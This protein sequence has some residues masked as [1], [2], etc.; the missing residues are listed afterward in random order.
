M[1]LMRKNML[2]RF[3]LFIDLCGIILSFLISAWIR[4]GEITK[5]WFHIKI[6]G[7]AFSIVIFIYIAIYFFHDTYS[8]L[9]KR[10]FF[11]EMIAV[12]RIN[13]I[14][15]ITLTVVMYLFQGGTYYSRI[16]FFCFFI[17]NT[18]IC[19]LLRQYFKVLLLGVY[20]KSSLSNKIMLIT[21]SNH[22]SNIIARIRNENE[23][24]YQITSLAIIDVDMVGKKI[25]GI[26]VKANIENMFNIA[27]REVIDGVFIHLPSDW[28][29]DIH[30]E[31]IVLELQNMGITVD[32]SINTFGLKIRE[33]VIRET[34]GYHVLTFSSKLF[35]ES[36]M[37]I[38]RMVDIL[39]GI[40]GCVITV[41]I[42][43]IIAPMI[44]LES[45]GPIFFTQIRIGKNGRR[46]K[47]YKFRSMYID[48]EQQKQEL[49]GLNEMNGLMFKI[50]NDPRVTQVGKF[51]R[52][53]SLDEFPQF[54]NVLKGEMSLVGTRPPTE[55]EFIQYEARHKRRLALKS[56]VT[57][58]W[59]VSGRS[60]ITDFEDVVKMDLEYI[61]NWSII[62]DFKIL[63][64]TVGVV[65]FG[66]GAK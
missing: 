33:K 34:S 50:K 49:M 16:F 54:F 63:I 47:L 9:F 26:E 30:L 23:W 46:F 56:G 64:K 62:M 58:L 18:L 31:E 19:Y 61:D 52:K 39:G 6:Y 5:E 43:V 1:D 41:I 15:A 13:G 22:I 36:Q 37:V 40:V 32:I 14:L 42:T 17:L 44:I 21:T 65:L 66:K 55:S 59:Q 24:E 29:N 7:T 2:S 25:D 8:R 27:K 45:P 51:L 12:L 28:I 57:G 20:K 4:F 38:K 3:L 35:N 11:E 10:G 60:N 48:A 53:T